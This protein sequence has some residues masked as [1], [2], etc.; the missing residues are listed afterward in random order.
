MSSEM[1][2]TLRQS[3]RANK[4]KANH[5][6]KSAF[7]L[8]IIIIF[9]E[10]GITQKRDSLNPKELTMPIRASYAAFHKEA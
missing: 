9:F 4:S 8:L 5:L 6:R 7:L 10:V 3:C 1:Y 2:K